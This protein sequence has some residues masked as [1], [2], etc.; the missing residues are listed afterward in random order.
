M[1][2]FLMVNMIGWAGAGA[3]LVA[4]ALVSSKKCEGTSLAYQGLN[5]AGS[6]LLIVN[7]V[8]FRA[9]PSAFVNLVWIGIGFL[10]V[11]TRGRN[12]RDR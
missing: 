5:M 4:Y 7:T 2:L 10:S 6:A 9:Y 8:Y 12:T 1:D 3:L 11:M